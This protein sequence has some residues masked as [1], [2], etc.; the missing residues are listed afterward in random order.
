M[1]SMVPSE[2]S[3]EHGEIIGVGRKIGSFWGVV[4]QEINVLFY[5]ETNLFQTPLL[6]SYYFAQPCPQK[7]GESRMSSPFCGV[8]VMVSFLSVGILY[9]GNWI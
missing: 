7:K 4:Y 9:R 6:L 8:H 3:N 2:D 1:G 5:S